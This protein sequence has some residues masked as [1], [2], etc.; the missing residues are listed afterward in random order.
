MSVKLVKNFDFV[1]QLSQSS[2]RDCTSLLQN[3]SID[4]IKVLCDICLNLLEGNIPVNG[5]EKQK[6][7]RYRKKN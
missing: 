3:V 1:K 5:E 4:K 6:L 2:K 7:K